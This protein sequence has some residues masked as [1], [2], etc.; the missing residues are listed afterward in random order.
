MSTSDNAVDIFFRCVNNFKQDPPNDPNAVA[1]MERIWLSAMNKWP[2]IY[3]AQ[4]YDHCKPGIPYRHD[5]LSENRL[6][7]HS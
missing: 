4:I 1:N 6:Y 3:T 2:P 5:K 7:V